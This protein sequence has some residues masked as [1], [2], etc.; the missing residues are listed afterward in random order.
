MEIRDFYQQLN[1]LSA[2][3]DPKLF[4]PERVNLLFQRYRE[5]TAIDF[6]EATDWIILT[7]PPAAQIFSVLDERLKAKREERPISERDSLYAHA[8]NA[9]ELADYYAPKIR[10]ML[11]RVTKKLPYDPAERIT[12]ENSVF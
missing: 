5:Y 2:S 11:Q 6:K 12:D 1:R 3:Y 7:L 10:E 4:P 8:P 9:K